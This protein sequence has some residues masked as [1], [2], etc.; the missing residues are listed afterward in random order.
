[1]ILRAI[2]C[3]CKDFCLSVTFD[4]STGKNDFDQS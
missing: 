1:M 4:Q 2:L 3:Y